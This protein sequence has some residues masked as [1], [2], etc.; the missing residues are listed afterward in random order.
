MMVNM[1]KE[2][3]Y[4]ISDTFFSKR[5]EEKYTY[6]ERKTK[7]E[8]PVNG[9]YYAELDHILTHRRWHNSIKDVKSDMKAN[10]QTYHFPLNKNTHNTV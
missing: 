6:R 9:E 3:E 8:D 10:I 2:T 5:P 1:A 7:K 4:R